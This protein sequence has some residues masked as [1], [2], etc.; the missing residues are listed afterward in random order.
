MFSRSFHC[1]LHTKA[2]RDA[3]SRKSSGRT[4]RR[5]K[6]GSTTKENFAVK[7]DGEG[8]LQIHG[9]GDQLIEVSVSPASLETV[10]AKSND[11]LASSKESSKTIFAMANW[12][13]GAIMGGILTSFTLLYVVGYTLG[14]LTWIINGSK[15]VMPIVKFHSK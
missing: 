6:F 4:E 5:R 2:D 12:K 7:V 10:A 3:N 14:F 15:P 9:I 1:S 13:F 11:F 8:F